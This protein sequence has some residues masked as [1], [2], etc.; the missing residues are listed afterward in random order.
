MQLCL[1]GLDGAV[2]FRVNRRDLGDIAVQRNIRSWHHGQRTAEFR[3][4]GIRIRAE[5]RRF[6]ISSLFSDK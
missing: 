6:A 4:N 2:N 3:L 5:A 1:A